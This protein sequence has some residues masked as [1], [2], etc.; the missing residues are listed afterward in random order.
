MLGGRIVRARQAYASVGFPDL[1]AG[2]HFPI[3]H[4]IVSIWSGTTGKMDD[5][6][7]SDIRRFETELIEYVGHHKPE[8]FETLAN[9]KAL[10]DDMVSALEQVVEEFKGQFQPSASASAE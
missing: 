8:L 7:V 4:E 1:E 9:A 6:Q 5:I 2:V 10:E 3:G